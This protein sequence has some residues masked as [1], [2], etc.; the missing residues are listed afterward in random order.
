[1]DDLLAELKEH[2]RRQIDE[3]RAVAKR[4]DELDKQI[5]ELERNHA[6]LLARLRLISE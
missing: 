4:L 2:K 6:K 3:N 5:I 1:M